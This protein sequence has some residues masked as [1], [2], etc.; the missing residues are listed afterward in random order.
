MVGIFVTLGLIFI[1]IAVSNFAKRRRQTSRLRVA[2]AKTAVDAT[3]MKYRQLLDISRDAILV[4]PMDGGAVLLANERASVITG[5]S[6]DELSRLRVSQIFPIHGGQDWLERAL[7]LGRGNFEPV[8]LQRRTGELVEVGADVAHSRHAGRMV[9]QIAFRPTHGITESR[10]SLD[11]HQEA[12]TALGLATEQVPPSLARLLE[13]IVD[14]IRDTLSLEMAAVVLKQPG[15]EQMTLWLRRE[16]APGLLSLSPPAPWLLDLVQATEEQKGAVVW[17]ANA[18]GWPTSLDALASE[19]LRIVAAVP[20]RMADHRQGLLLL[21]SHTP[22]LL[23]PREWEALIQ[24]GADAER[25]AEVAW[26]YTRLAKAADTLAHMEQLYRQLLDVTPQAMAAV[27]AFGR[28]TYYNQA[29]QQLLLLP[30]KA[31]V[32]QTLGELTDGQGALARL[33][34]QVTEAGMGPA[35]HRIHL[36]PPTGEEMWVDVHIVPFTDSHGKIT[37]AS[38]ALTPVRRE[39]EEATW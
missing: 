32:G 4:A 2:R 21:G 5:Y 13:T 16:I 20:L 37:G 15:R 34:R 36:T 9:L 11:P 39:I 35:R 17:M 29:A 25:A 30:A 26:Q 3:E 33:L 12:H 18:D 23:A 22:R 27:D 31:G 10:E 38:V 14:R 24:A 7:V 19:G 28:L 6:M 1:L 8:D